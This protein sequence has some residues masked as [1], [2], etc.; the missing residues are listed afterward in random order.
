MWRLKTKPLSES[1]YL[2]MMTCKR[3]GKF[4]C[5]TRYSSFCKRGISREAVFL[6][7]KMRFTRKT[8]GHF[9]LDW[10]DRVI[11]QIIIAMTWPY[12]LVCLSTSADGSLERNLVALYISSHALLSFLF[13]ANL[14]T[15][16]S[17]DAVSSQRAQGR[18]TCLIQINLMKW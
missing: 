16:V 2:D 4:D 18:R 14:F 8:C 9:K 12:C 13:L 11:L 5:S 1:K 3:V 15:G 6:R 17:S 10:S 7:M